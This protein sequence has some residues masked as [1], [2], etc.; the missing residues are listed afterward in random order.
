[1]SC[2]DQ[3]R[4]PLDDHN[5]PDQL[6]ARRPDRFRPEDGDELSVIVL[7]AAAPAIFGIN[8]AYFDGLRG[9]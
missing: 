1:M 2:S 9:R 4:F 8:L 6:R 7:L 3:H 5:R